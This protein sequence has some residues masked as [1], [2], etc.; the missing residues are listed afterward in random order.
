MSEMRAINSTGDTKVTWD[1]DN[2][3][4]VEAARK[5]FDEYIAKGFTAYKGKPKGKK[6]T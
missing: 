5:S 3:R 4:E 1:S 2:P 6:G